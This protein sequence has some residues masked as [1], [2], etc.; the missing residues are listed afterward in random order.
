M[1]YASY[2]PAGLWRFFVRKKPN[3]DPFR[4]TDR[5]TY[6]QRDLPFAG[7]PSGQ[8]TSDCVLSAS[9]YASF[10][11]ESFP[12]WVGSYTSQGGNG[13]D[14]IIVTSDGWA[15]AVATMDGGRPGQL[16]YF[17]GPGLGEPG[18]GRIGGWVVAGP[19]VAVRN[20]HSVVCWIQQ[21]INTPYAPI[22]APS[23]AYTRYLIDNVPFRSSQVETLVS[24][25]YSTEDPTQADA[26]ERFWYAS[27]IGK[28]RWERWSRDPPV[29]DDALNPTQIPYGWPS[30]TLSQGLRLSDLRNY[31]N[32][33]LTPALPAGLPQV[34]P[35][36]IA[37]TGWPPNFVLP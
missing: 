14:V 6:R 31:T 22:G 5:L 24:E 32:I 23:P 2:S 7:W 35:F 3:G 30:P 4:D 11:Y 19:D 26:V 20:W 33:V 34:A 29:P 15:K 18:D 27:G 17:V 10:D 16:Y 36:T 25:H 8:E 21:S 9:G 1:A 28:I 12:P 13:G 37:S